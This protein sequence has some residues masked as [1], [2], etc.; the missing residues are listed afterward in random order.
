MLKYLL[1]SI[2]GLSVLMPVSAAPLSE[3]EVMA[4]AKRRLAQAMHVHV[5]TPELRKQLMAEFHPY[6]LAQTPDGLIVQLN[7]AQKLALAARG[8]W[9]APA[10]TW[11]AAHL[12][13]LKKQ[14]EQRRKPDWCYPTVEE[15]RVEAERLARIWPERVTLIDIG[16]SWEKTQ[17]LAD[18]DLLVLRI[19]PKTG[20][21]EAKLLLTAGVHAREMAP[22][23]LVLDFIRDLLRRDGV[24]P[25]ITY[26]LD[27]RELHVALL[28]NPDGRKYAEQNLL[29]RKNTN[30]NYCPQSPDL[31]GADLNRNFSFNWGGSLSNSAGGAHASTDQCDETYLGRAAASEPETRAIEAYARRLF[32]D[33]R[34]D[35]FSTPAPVSKPGIFVDIHSFSELVLYPWGHDYTPLP[36][37]GL[38]ALA[39]RTA[40]INRY[41]PMAAVS[42][43]PTT[44]TTDDFGYGEL[45][46]ASLTFEIGRQFF[47]PCSSYESDVRPGNL[48]A[49]HYLWRMA[50]APYLSGN[51]PRIVRSQQQWDSSGV[52]I[53]IDVESCQRV[54]CQQ[55]AITAAEYA[56]DAPV[57]EQG[58]VAMTLIDS[59]STT[60]TSFE[61]RIDRNQLGNLPR[62]LFVRAANAEG[63][64]SPPFALTVHEQSLPP[65]A[66]ADIDCEGTSC[67]FD[68]SES[69]SPDG[70]IVAWRWYVDDIEVGQGT[71]FVHTLSDGTHDVTLAVEDNHQQTNTLTRTI[72]VGVSEQKPTATLS[73]TCNALSCT[74]DWSANDDGQVVAV[75]ID[76]GDGQVTSAPARPEQHHYQKAGNYQIRLTATDDIG[77]RTSV[78]AYVAPT[79]QDEGH[80][81]GGENNTS[82][83]GGGGGAWSWLLLL[84][85]ARYRRP[86]RRW[87]RNFE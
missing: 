81:G 2:I 13:W 48:D 32:A 82:D 56:W 69:T 15:T 38:A 52:T 36:N 12:A 29:W 77:Q 67:T 17:G 44:G 72:T 43:Y 78:V 54:G 11:K 50:D 35:D 86:R 24:D 21:A 49:L 84:F 41:T 19:G 64:W 87:Q 39:E 51:R 10:Q 75:E 8:F 28:V 74:L 37:P 30:T 79:T 5:V 20:E 62:T 6:L 57:P 65:V 31:R 7:D 47:E 71:N 25:E 60:D 22:P 3:A 58:G 42:L 18:R 53:R 4:M 40:Q 16:D 68:G 9:V 14:L 1:S 55:S 83:S 26:F 76:W 33:D 85:G 73:A 70:H 63:R 23:L 45:G 59:G 61:A 27:H 34:P 80:G 66:R 46:V